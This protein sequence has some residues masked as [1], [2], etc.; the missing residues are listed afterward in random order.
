MTLAVDGVARG[1]SE[2]VVIA[3][4][5]EVVLPLVGAVAD[6]V[7]GVE[8]R[9]NASGSCVNE[10]SNAVVRHGDGRGRVGV[11]GAREITRVVVGVVGD[12]T[13]RP[14]AASEFAVGRVRVGRALYLKQNHTTTPHTIN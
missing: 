11:F 2:G 12:D 9:D 14:R 8:I 1:A 10:V 4:Q 3:R 13:S 7:V 5:V 6:E